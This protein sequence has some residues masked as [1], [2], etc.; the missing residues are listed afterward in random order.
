M[1]RVFRE[2]GLVRALVEEDVLPPCLRQELL[3]WEANHLHDE[4]QLLLL[5]FPR[6][7]R[8]PGEQF[9]EYA[10]EAPHV[11][12]GRVRYPEDDLWGPVEP[13]LNVGIYPLV[14]KA[15]GAK[16]DDLD[17]R[18]IG[19]LQKNVLGLEVTMDE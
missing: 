1:L 3:V 15:A 5:R 12:C 18:L 7:E 14:C 4:G 11:D 10:A 9:R 8:D 6:E 13:G 17:A 2:V 19:A 16:V